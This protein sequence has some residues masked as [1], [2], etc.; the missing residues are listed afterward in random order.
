MIFHS[1]ND[2]YNVIFIEPGSDATGDKSFYQASSTGTGVV[3]SDATVF[4]TGTRSIRLESASGVG[5]SCSLQFYF[6]TNGNT[7]IYNGARLSFYVRFA[8]Y[9]IQDNGPALRIS[10]LFVILGGSSHYALGIDHLGRLRLGWYSALFSPLDYSQI[11][12]YGSTLLVDTWYRISLCYNWIN[13]DIDKVRVYVDGNL[14][15]AVQNTGAPSGATYAR[16]IYG[17][18]S[19]N[20]G[21]GKIFYID[22]VYFDDNDTCHDPGDIRVTSKKPSSNNVNNFPIAIGN[23]PSNRWENVNEI[24]LNVLNGWLENVGTSTVD[25]NYGIESS[26][27]GDVD[28]SGYSGVYPNSLPSAGVSTKWSGGLYLYECGVNIAVNNSEM[29]IVDSKPWAFLSTSVG[30]VNSIN[31]VYLYSNGSTRYLNDGGAGRPYSALAGGNLNTV[32]KLFFPYFDTGNVFKPFRFY[33][34][35]NVEPFIFSSRD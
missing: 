9:P 24:P 17:W 25:E 29:K 3:E 10:G 35:S 4:N 1:R 31:Q 32:S 23:N 18:N 7:K 21:N 12:P 2:G 33:S 28:I 16:V 22:D 8:N 11:G 13:S 14:D 34:R 5:G 27:S 6:A 26:S 15:I 19:V 20:V 30:T